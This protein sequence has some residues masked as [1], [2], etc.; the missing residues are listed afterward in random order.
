MPSV[1]GTSYSINSQDL[2]WQELH[3]YYKISVALGRPSK[4]Q[5]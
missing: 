5:L 2:A 1:T 3:I 4:L